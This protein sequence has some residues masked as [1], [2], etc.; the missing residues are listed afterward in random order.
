MEP[1]IDS[2]EGTLLGGGV[3]YAQ[4]REGFRSGIE[5][6]LLAAFV[7][8]RAGEQVLE[9]GCGAGAALLCLAARVPGVGGTG[10]ERDPALVALAAA[11]A[12]ANGFA[13]L[14]FVPG[15]VLAGDPG[16]TFDHCCANPPYHPGGGTPS[17]LAERESAKR[18]GPGLLGAWTAAL[19]QR[20]RA[21]GS[22]TLI[23]AAAGVPEVL[24]AMAASGIGG[25]VLLPLWPK[26]ERAAKLVLLRGVKGGRAPFRLLPGLVL[27]RAD[28]GFTEP[29]EAV[30]RAGAGL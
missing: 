6:V 9:A 2:T 18:A 3:R 22:L 17:P 26:P 12:V 28:G 10:V 25:A 30:L 8:A 27:H 13:G 20:L 1:P 19:G 11:N 23:L 15:D 14:R 7:P 24:A 4:P 21:G 29:A 16:G 5:P